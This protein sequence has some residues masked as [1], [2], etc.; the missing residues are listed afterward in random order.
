[1]QGVVRVG[2]VLFQV[3][4]YC[5]WA[6]TALSQTAVSGH[7]T[8]NRIVEPV[9]EAA[10]VTLAGNVHPL[11]RGEFDD[12]VVSAETPLNRMILVL[13]PSA[14]QQA[15]LDSLLEAQ[16]D[17]ESPLY[18]KWLTP[19]EYGSR[20]G[21]SAGD[22]ARVTAWLAGHGFVVDEIAASGRLVLF[23]GNAGKVA[24]TFHTEIHRYM[25]NG[26]EHIGNAQDPQIP[27]A[28]AGVVGGVV[29]LHNFRR[30]SEIKARKELSS[31]FGAQPQ[32]TSGSTHYLFPAD[33]A[34]I[35]DLNSLYGAG[36]KGAGTSIAITG[37]SNI[38]LSD[39]A[40]FVRLPG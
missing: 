14:A 8:V 19:A 6:V 5:G 22:L 11:A 27:A 34:T 33:W 35:Y 20:F 25:V 21:A 28:L 32:Y 13:E 30:T 4:M 18:H 16:H 10:V 23:S 12:G 31:G 39:V 17:P 38:N 24:D 1:M 2:F 9:Q 36:T 37:R 3:M 29:T 15:E 26:V 40:R 7:P